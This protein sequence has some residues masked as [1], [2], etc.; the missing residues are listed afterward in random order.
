[1][2]WTFL[3]ELRERRPE[4]IEGAF[5]VHLLCEA[6]GQRGL[7]QI[8][9][10]DIRRGWAC[11]TTTQPLQRRPITVTTSASLC[12]TSVARGPGTVLRQ[13]VS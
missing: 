4:P 9:P 12:N 6:A 5:E 8:N 3:T 10:A 13:W 7:M 1:M 11:P 2:V